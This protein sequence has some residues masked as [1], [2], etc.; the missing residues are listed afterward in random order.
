LSLS[1]LQT[2]LLIV[3]GIWGLILASLA[4]ALVAWLLIKKKKPNFV[5]PVDS[6]VDL[7]L[8]H[9]VIDTVNEPP[10]IFLG[11]IK[12]LNR[13][14]ENFDWGVIISG[15]GGKPGI[16][17]TAL[18]RALARRLSKRYPG[19]CVEINMGG[20]QPLGASEAMGRLL[21]TLNPKVKLP[22]SEA[23][24]NKLYRETIQRNAVLVVLDNVKDAEQVKS[25]LPTTPSALIAT[26]Q[27]GK[28]G[29][30]LGLQ[31]FNLTGLLPEDAVK[32]L[33][34]VADRLKKNT[35]EE[36]SSIAQQCGYLPLAL[37]MAG[38][39][40]KMNPNWTPER[41]VERMKRVREQLLET[42]EE[43]VGLE[44]DI[45]LTLMYQALG[46]ILQYR[47]RMLG[48]FSGPFT[49]SAAA[50]VWSCDKE[51]AL[52]DI[53]KLWF[54]NLLEWQD[55]SKAYCMHE[56][57][58]SFAL[59]KLLEQPDDAS[60]AA[61]RHAKYYL[62]QGKVAIESNHYKKEAGNGELRGFREIWPQLQSAWMRM[63]GRQEGWPRSDDEHQ[64][65]ALAASYLGEALAEH[66][67]EKDWRPFFES[68]I[69]ASQILKD[70]SQEA[71]LALQLGK[72]YHKR[73]EVEWAKMYILQALILFQELEDS[74]GEGE[75]MAYLGFLHAENGDS[76]N[77]H[78]FFERALTILPQQPET[79]KLANLIA[80]TLVRQ[81][82]YA[83]AEQ[84]MKLVGAPVEG[85]A[86][87]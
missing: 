14:S 22:E 45:V 4:V 61:L 50:Y 15:K 20:P 1:F 21:I 10:K 24:L 26:V 46:E 72:T 12:E 3:I 54:F 33:R 81:G 69:E 40:L 35:S 87:G 65:L 56:S 75:A 83:L 17:K 32:L 52:E 38:S 80:A 44:V 2:L 16:G 76:E 59:E 77:A 57:I 73:Q 74:S 18:A 5:L 27:N 13:L 71:R 82:E 9:A 6:L 62:K 29:S 84:L 36:L 37:R 8:S 11:R 34:I 85:H 79:T 25:L 78:V 55:K 23:E 53:R 30:E 63:T 7:D 67:S 43:T 70:K 66:L 28:G 86:N 47:F 64:W 42:R 31:V 49:A 51:L 68:G 39:L 48:S 41:L 58:Y 60:Q 19:G